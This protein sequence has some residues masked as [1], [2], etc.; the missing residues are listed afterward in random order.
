MDTPTIDFW[1]SVGSILISLHLAD[2]GDCEGERHNLSLAVV[3]RA[4]DYG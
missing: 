4:V 2:R 1:I 3:F